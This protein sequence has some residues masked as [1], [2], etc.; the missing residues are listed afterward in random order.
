MNGILIVVNGLQISDKIVDEI[1][2]SSS[3]HLRKYGFRKMSLAKLA[4][5]CQA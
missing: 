1:I 5:I 3:K 4:R 2:V